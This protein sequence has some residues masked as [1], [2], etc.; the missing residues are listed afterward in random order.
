MEQIRFFF[1]LKSKGNVVVSKT[2]PVRIDEEY[3]FFFGSFGLPDRDS[4]NILY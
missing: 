3:I 1:P 4:L 2:R